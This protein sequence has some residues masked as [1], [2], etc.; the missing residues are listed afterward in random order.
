MNV[1]DAQHQ[2]LVS[3]RIQ[4]IELRAIAD[5][6]IGQI[7]LIRAGPIDEIL[8]GPRGA[9]EEITMSAFAR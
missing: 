4:V 1:K 2:A 6:R 5:G 9:L 8:R 3:D 7:Q